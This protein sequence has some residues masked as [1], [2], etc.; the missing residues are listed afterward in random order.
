MSN[1]LSS[2]EDDFI[3]Y[4]AIIINDETNKGSSIYTVG[5]PIRVGLIS[6]L[7]KNIRQPDIKITMNGQFGNP[8][9]VIYKLE[10][11]TLPL[12]HLFIDGF[13]LAVGAAFIAN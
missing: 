12:N 10:Y 4:H 1:I 8:L 5:E 3:I 9:I 7:K 11:S 13:K 2:G 6:E